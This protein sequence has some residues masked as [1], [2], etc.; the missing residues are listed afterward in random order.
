MRKALELNEAE[1][2]VLIDILNQKIRRL[3]AYRDTHEKYWGT[4]DAE[5]LAYRIKLRDKILDFSY[6]Q[7]MLDKED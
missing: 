5:V 1:C 4:T 7:E 6:R 2:R 3:E